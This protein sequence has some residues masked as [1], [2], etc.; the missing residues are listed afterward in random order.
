MQSEM[1]EPLA[2]NPVIAPIC[3]VAVRVSVEMSSFV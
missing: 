1:V 3:S 2:E